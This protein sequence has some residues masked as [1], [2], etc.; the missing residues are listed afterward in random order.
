MSETT[1]EIFRAQLYRLTTIIACVLAIL[2]IVNAVAA[3]NSYGMSIN[4]LYGL[5]SGI[6]G[7]VV[8]VV[9]A[10]IFKPKPKKDTNNN[11]IGGDP[12]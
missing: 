5:S 11:S 9:L 8:A 10:L 2:L 4:I 7:F 6:I 3:A 1:A 12:E